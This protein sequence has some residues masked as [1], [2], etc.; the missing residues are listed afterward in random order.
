MPRILAT[1]AIAFVL[2]IVVLANRGV[3]YDYLPFIQ[4]IPLLDKA[5]HFCLMGGVAFFVN[6]ALRGQRLQVLGRD[7]FLGS[8]LVFA[9]VL[10]EELS[11]IF[12]ATRNFDLVD[13]LADGLGILVLGTLGGRLGARA[14]VPDSPNN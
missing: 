9:C 6:L 3:L 11:Q 5:G 2:W 7:C 8:L 4:N 10:L 1:L 13:L 12:I 14:P